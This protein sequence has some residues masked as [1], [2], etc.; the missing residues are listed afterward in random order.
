MNTVNI[1]ADKLTFAKLYFTVSKTGT[2]KDFK[3]DRS[4]GHPASDQKIRELLKST[5][6][7]WQAAENDKGEKVE[8]GLVVS[9]GG[10]G[11]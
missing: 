5:A 3:L 11:C 9:F 1:D 2:L 8:Q 10:D 4:C 7:Q 6:D